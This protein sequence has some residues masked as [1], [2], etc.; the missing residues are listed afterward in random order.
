MPE[1]FIPVWMSVGEAENFRSLLQ[2]LGEDPMAEFPEREF[3]LIDSALRE[4]RP[5]SFEEMEVEGG[6]GVTYD[7]DDA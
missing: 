3:D 6:G 7:G 5:R 2:E 4:Q 1:S